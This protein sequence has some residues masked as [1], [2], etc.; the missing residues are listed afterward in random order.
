MRFEVEIQGVVQGVGFRPFIYALANSM[1]LSG[2]VLNNSYGVKIEVEA[3]KEELKNF[4][5]EIYK[6]PPTLSRIDFLQSKKVESQEN[7]NGFKIVQ[8]QKEKTSFVFMPPDIGMCKEC[9]KEFEDK[10][11]KR[12]EYPFISCLDCGPRYS[13]INAFPYD[14]NNSSMVAFKM[15]PSCLE[16]YSN[17]SNRRYHAQTISCFECG[18]KLFLYNQKKEQLKQSELL[19]EASKLLKSGKIVALKGIGGYQLLCDAKNDDAVRLLRER[20]K[21]ASKP[22][23]VMYESLEAVQK[24]AKVSKQEADLLCSY[25]KQIV[26][27]KKSDSFSLSIFIAPKIEQI[28]AFLAPSPL[29][30]LLLKKVKTAL[31]VT[32][33]NISTEPICTTFEEIMRLSNVWDYLLDNDREIVNACDDSV[34]F[35]EQGKRFMLRAARGYFL[36]H[37]QLPEPPSKNVLCLGANQKSTIAFS[38]QGKVV[39]SQYMGDLD[40]LASIEKFKSFIEKMKTFYG[41]EFEKIACDKHPAYESTKYA[42]ELIKENP[43]IK[44]TQVQHH[45]AH[46]LATMG[47]NNLYSKVLGVSFDGA[48]YGEDGSL[49]GGEFLI[50]DTKSYKRVAHFKEFKLLGASKAIKEPRRVALSLLFDLYKKDVLGLK[51]AVTDAFEQEELKTLYQVWKNG[52]NSP[53]SSSVGRL[54]DGV[55]SIL[56]VIQVC[57]YEGE[58]GLLLET[59]Y[60]EKVQEAFSFY[61]EDGVIDFSEVFYQIIEEEDRGVAVSK[62]FNTLVAII[63]EV[64]QQYDLRVA[65]GGGV[66]QNRVL[67][68][69]IMQK[70]PDVL[71]PQEFVSNDSAIAY[72]QMVALSFFEPII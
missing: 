37:L 45:H 11:N 52:L 16:E 31:L 59:L 43:H 66:F 19:Q 40:S 49:W 39:V 3:T 10:T 68:R 51:N 29:H 26:L 61:I 72:G 1:S 55:A 67:L 6:K 65:L 56:G 38:V 4:I 48:G 69:L 70:I 42:F 8:S 27:L 60:D 46:I 34:A 22:F 24:D 23:A 18:P 54:F 25:Q 41:V 15:C 32:S 36:S 20:K 12:Y 2:Y 30:Q 62:F 13:I 44:L 21:R 33:A 35:V 7:F 17:P 64:H 57:S 63:Y 50:C 14:R 53:L 71:L 47:V 5:Q 58:S 9:Q 28:G